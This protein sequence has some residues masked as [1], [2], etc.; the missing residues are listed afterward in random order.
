MRDVLH[1]SQRTVYNSN[2]CQMLAS[3]FN[4]FF[5]DKLARIHDTIAVSLQLSSEP[6][7][8]P[9]LH[10]GPTLSQLAPTSAAEV[11]K[12]L[13]STRLKASPLDVLP[14]ALLRSCATAFAPVIAHMA[15]LSFSEGCFP[16]ASKTAC[17]L[18]LLKKP[19]L[20]TEQMSNYRPI[21]SLTTVS[22]VIERLVLNRFRPYLLSSKNFARLQSAYR[23]AHSTETALLHIMNTVYTA[24]DN[25]NVTALV[26][27]DISAALDHDIL[28]D[29]LETQLCVNGAALRLRSYLSDSS[30][31]SAATRPA[32]PSGASTVCHKDPCWVRFCSRRTCHQSAS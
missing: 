20:N 27:L 8:S 25:I 4:Q 24:A 22:K 3:G 14:T 18:P 6:F 2:Q 31:D 1:S 28:I 17:V 13:S 29:R 30:C 32:R 23:P 19:G 26:A 16:A 15:N 9:R 5:M 21:S 11:L 10:T 7:S 12:V